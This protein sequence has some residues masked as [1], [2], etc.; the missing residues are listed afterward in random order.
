MRTLKATSYE[1]DSVLEAA[2]RNSNFESGLYEKLQ[3]DMKLPFLQSIHKQADGAGFENVYHEI[4][5]TLRFSDG[6]TVSDK[7]TIRSVFLKAGRNTA[8]LA[9]SSACLQQKRRPLYDAQHCD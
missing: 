5:L 3:K 7:L 1:E 6:T 2:I 8:Q 9:A 4:H